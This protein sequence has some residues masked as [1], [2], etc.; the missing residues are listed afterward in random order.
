[1][2]PCNDV[3]QAADDDRMEIAAIDPAAST[4]AVD[5]SAFEGIAAAIE[6]KL[7]A[8]IEQV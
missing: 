7:R 4:A 1:M 8:A 2:L 3:V 5:N 6:A